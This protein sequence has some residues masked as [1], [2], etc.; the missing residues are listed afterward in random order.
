MKNQDKIG[1][2]GPSIGLYE[3]RGDINDFWKD[4]IPYVMQRKDK[5]RI[6][7]LLIHNVNKFREIIL[8]MVPTDSAQKSRVTF[9]PTDL[10]L[11]LGA[12]IRAHDDDQIFIIEHEVNSS[13]S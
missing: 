2:L 3:D 9:E 12:A 11:R 4:L 6:Q 10:M 1:I 7:F 8:H 13:V 5:E